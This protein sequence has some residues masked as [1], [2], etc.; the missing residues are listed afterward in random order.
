MVLQRL[1]GVSEV[2][3]LICYDVVFSQEGVLLVLVLEKGETNLS[4]YLLNTK[5]LSAP[6][7]LYLWEEILSSI[8]AL[9]RRFCS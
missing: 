4:S 6:S 3:Q 5:S 1:T 8:G 7:L 9:H 2:V